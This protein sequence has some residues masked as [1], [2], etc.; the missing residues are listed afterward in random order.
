MFV[1]ACFLFFVCLEFQ[2]IWFVINT[3]TPIF[4]IE[5]SFVLLPPPLPPDT[6]IC[7]SGVAAEVV[8]AAALDGLLSL[9]TPDQGSRWRNRLCNSL[10][11]CLTPAAAA[12]AASLLH[13]VIRLLQPSDQRHPGLHSWA[14]KKIPDVIVGGPGGGGAF[15]YRNKNTLK[16]SILTIVSVHVHS[17]NGV[18]Q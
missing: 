12:T 7:S 18:H 2:I 14:L 8:A 6:Q 11:H 3:F 17:N 10:G 15:L 1:F 13:A 9:I 5:I 16:W 4:F